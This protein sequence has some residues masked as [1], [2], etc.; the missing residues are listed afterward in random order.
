[1]HFAANF[2]PLALPTTGATGSKAAELAARPRRGGGVAT[3]GHVRHLEEHMNRRVLLA[4]AAAAV[5]A[6]TGV[7]TASAAGTSS[8]SSATIT[9]R[10]VKG[11][12][13]TVLNAN[14]N[15]YAD[16]K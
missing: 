10:E 11:G 13:K 1:M 5:M 6:S 14:T 3:V 7:L 15:F 2:D 4:L 9:T 8:T 12:Q 16:E